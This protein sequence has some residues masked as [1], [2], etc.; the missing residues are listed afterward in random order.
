MLSHRQRAR[1]RRIDH[2]IDRLIGRARK[3]FILVDWL[4]PSLVRAAQ[5]RQA[6]RERPAAP[7]AVSERLP[8]ELET[9][10][11]DLNRS[12]SSGYQFGELR[13]GSHLVFEDTD[14]PD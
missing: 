14:F 9:R 3:G 8:P 5:N 4:A 10:R 13:V 7:V 11:P 6:R 1:A 12:G 2:T